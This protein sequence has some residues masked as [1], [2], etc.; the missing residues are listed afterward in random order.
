MD[1]M[2]LWKGTGARFLLETKT[3][4]APPAVSQMC[5]LQSPQSLPL[6]FLT[7]DQIQSRAPTSVLP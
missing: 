1:M 6:L 4:M 3:P 5:P 2:R 7:P